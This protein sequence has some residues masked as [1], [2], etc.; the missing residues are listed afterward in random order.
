M[1]EYVLVKWHDLLLVLEPNSLEERHGELWM[2]CVRVE[3]E[4]NLYKI[5]GSHIAHWE[6]GKECFETICEMTKVRDKWFVR[7]E[8]LDG[9]D[10]K[11]R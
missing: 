7:K 9:F 6:S 10:W 1:E 11:W 5:G 8:D 3:K 2:K 4:E